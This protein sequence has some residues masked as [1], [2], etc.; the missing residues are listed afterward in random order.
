MPSHAQGVQAVRSS[1]AVIRS[2]SSATGVFCCGGLLD[3]LV[4]HIGDIDHQVT[5]KPLYTR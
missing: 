1:S 3:E 4:V 5:S 2:A